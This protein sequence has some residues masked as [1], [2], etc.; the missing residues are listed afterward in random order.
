MQNDSVFNSGDFFQFIGSEMAPTPYAGQ[1]IYNK[2]NVYWFSYQADS[3][4]SYIS[5][6]GY[7]TN[8]WPK[9]IS[10][11]NTIHYEKDLIFERLG[12]ASNNLERD[13]WFWDKS[14]FRGGNQTY[15]FNY[16]INHIDSNINTTLPQARVRLNVTGINLINCSPGH[17]GYIKFNSQK[18][19]NFTYPGSSQQN[20]T[21]EK[22]FVFGFGS[23]IV[24]D[25]IH[26]RW[27]Y[28]YF[29]I[30]IDS[31]SCLTSGD[32][33]NRINWVEFDYWRYNRVNGQ[34][35]IFKSPPNQNG[36][37]NFYIW[38]WD[39]DNMKV[40]I[41][42]RSKMITNPFITNDLDKG[43][44]FVD[45][46]ITRTEYFL[47]SED[48]YLSPDS[49]KKDSSSD[50]RNTH[51]EADYIIISHPDFFEVAQRLADYRRNNIQGI[52][53]AR[54][55]VVNIYDVYDEF[56]YGLMD[57]YAL[58][59]FT[60]YAFENYQNPAPS[61]IVLLGDMSFDY[62]GIYENSR[63]NF[64]PSI[65][66]QSTIYGQAPS[67]NNIVTVAGNDMVPDLATG[68][69]SCESIEEAN[70]LVDK[71]INY[72]ADI[73]KE[74][75]QNV[76]LLS[77]GLSAEDENNY[78]FN[79]RNMFLANNYIDPA[80][81]KSTKVFR[82]PNKPEYIQYQGD[83]P[84]I[85]REIDN[86]SVIVNYYGHG[87]GEQW[88]LVF[89]NDDILAL[90]NGGR[91]PFVV[92]VTCYTAHYDNQEIFGEIFNSIPGKGSIA[93]FGSS[94]VTFWP[95]TAVINQDLF[96]EIFN[97]K[98]Y[99]IGDAI[100][101]A[102]A[103]PG[104]GTMLALLTLLGDPALELALPYNADFVI[105]PSNLSI[106]PFNPLVD[107]TV[108]VLLKI[109]NLG[110]SFGEDSVKVE[111][112]YNL[113]SDSTLVGVNKLGSFGE[114]DSTFFTWIPKE[115][116]LINLIAVI[117]GDQAVIEDD[118][119]DNTALNGF[120]VFSVD[121]PKILK[122]LNYIYTQENN[123]DFILVDVGNYVGQNFSYKI[124]IDTSYDM[125]SNYIITSPI[126]YPEKGLVKWITPELA[127]NQYFWKAFIYSDQDTNS[128]DIQTFSI[129]SISGNGFLSHST[130]LK[131][132]I[133]ENI[134]FSDLKNGLLLNTELLPPRP[135]ERRLL[136]SILTV[137]I[138]PDTTEI[139][140]CT[141]D[142][143]YLYFGELTY[144]RQGR[145]SNIYKVGTGLNGSIKGQNYGIIPNVE[146]AIKNQIFYHSD[147]FLYI[148][149]GDDS[150]L[151]RVNVLIWRYIKGIN[152]WE[153][154]TF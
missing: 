131:T 28:N 25:S 41:P 74:W 53:N 151:L 51:N 17:S 140:T 1:N 93:F 14:E 88:D 142:G 60:K 112:Y 48:S 7:P 85:R 110:R 101:K 109:R 82:Y 132:F 150:T 115:D 20:Y 68:R 64:I 67:D 106:Y 130:Q 144:Y 149:T 49:I 71:I 103:N 58:Q 56:S 78:K 63:P 117:N 3:V 65:P 84:D 43:V 96:K 9:V 57:P 145:K 46:A 98:Q 52:N 129:S 116:G 24:D 81:I 95:T 13:Y 29:E 15:I 134:L 126:L 26:Y 108:K 77:S 123:I 61:Y 91:L 86:G 102:K 87:G 47:V 104:Y 153:A 107:D 120:A 16:E 119:A 139:T 12:Y 79:D 34:N 76:L 22:D 62:R 69:I 50:L 80:G 133:N 23:E 135:G 42:Q 32:D 10:N 39:A 152:S 4:N 114:E 18:I 11:Q 8:T 127:A 72:P 128:S 19:G 36:R 73:G 92:S 154:L 113:I 121:K 137:N 146:A 124:Q 138:S 89:T 31:P 37:F 136:D 111:L 33:I 30:G 55:K 83:G 143:T 2:S 44:Y 97:E 5:K 27:G 66:Y 122:P 38:Q 54:T 99:V 141:T 59:Y 100:L 105:K 35:Y 125:S 90:N 70:L 118:Y 94:G 148:A 21:F 75:K 147:G 45:T 40:Y 6:N